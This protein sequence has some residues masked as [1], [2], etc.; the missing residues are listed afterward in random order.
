MRA[1]FFSK[2]LYAADAP[3]DGSCG[4]ALILDQFV[5]IALNDLHD[6][7][8]PETGGWSADTYQRWLDHAHALAQQHI[9]PNGTPTRPDAVEKAYFQHGRSLWR[10]RRSPRR[11]RSL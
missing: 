10:S 2:F 4:R 9:L 6:W 11:R 1:S 5:A 8:L 3:G 7:E